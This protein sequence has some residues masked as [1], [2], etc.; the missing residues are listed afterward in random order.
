MVMKLLRAAAR[1]LRLKKAWRLPKR[2]DVLIFD[3]GR[4]SGYDQ[5]LE[6]LLRPY[7]VESMPLI[8]R[9]LNILVLLASLFMPGNR[10]IAY[11][12]S[13]IRRV[14]PKLVLTYVDNHTDFYSFAVRNPWIKTMF[15]QNGI[16]GYFADAFETLDKK[17][18]AEI[19]K[20]DFMMTFGSLVGA[21]YAKYVSGKVVP[22]GSF[23]NN[24]VP[25]RRQK[26]RDTLAFISQYRDTSGFDF[27]GAFYSFEQFW[28]QA[29]RLIIP[30]LVEYAKARGK[31]FQIVPCSDD[32]KDPALLEK[33]KSYY[34]RIAGFECAYSEW[35]WHGSSY[36]VIDAT[37]VIVAI[38]TS[39]GL[40]AMARGSRAA[41]F[42]IRSTILSLINQPSMNY[43]WP[44]NYPDDGPFWTNR[45]DP[46][47]FERI[48]DHLF[49]ASDEEWHTD[50]QREH[51][52][53]VLQYDPGNSILRGILQ[54]ELG[55]G[56]DH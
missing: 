53:D 19:L 41:I 30:F 21:E 5:G 44:G 31:T 34:N 26:V 45:P 23:R 29:D 46:A 10:K 17:P 49:S 18:P 47:A 42:S 35:Q 20:V 28:E 7:A 27:G 33:E 15:I 13:Y 9:K 43:G 50:L 22:I 40:E 51:F 24:L 52:A 8:D 55:S 1:A 54:S 25:V 6:E 56:R 32:Y 36:D 3:V 14:S 48:L 11:Y 38:D 4:N 16:R 37:E 39:M 12:D 2:A